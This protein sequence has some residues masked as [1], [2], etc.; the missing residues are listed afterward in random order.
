MVSRG[1]SRSDIVKG[2]HLSMA[3][4]YT[5]LLRSISVCGDENSFL[6]LRGRHVQEDF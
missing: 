4:R 2:I 6:R 5:K 1:M 3:G